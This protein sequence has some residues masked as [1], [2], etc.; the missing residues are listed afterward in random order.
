MVIGGEGKLESESLLSGE[1]CLLGTTYA[2]EGGEYEPISLVSLGE[3]S[4]FYF[5]SFVSG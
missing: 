2:P 5:S 1:I 4:L 3:V